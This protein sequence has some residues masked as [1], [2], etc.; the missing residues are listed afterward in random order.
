MVLFSINV[1]KSLKSTPID[2]HSIDS[3]TSAFR[4]VR[5][6]N[7]QHKCNLHKNA[8]SSL[9]VNSTGSHDIANKLIVG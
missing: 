4:I 2:S 1:S 9:F 3:N 8:I 5:Y 6:C 7:I